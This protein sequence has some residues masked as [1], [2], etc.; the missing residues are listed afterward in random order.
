[1]ASSGIARECL[2]DMLRLSALFQRT[3][4]IL[5]AYVYRP[6]AVAEAD[7]EYLAGETLPYIDHVRDGL[8]WTLRASDADLDELRYLV[9]IAE[10]RPVESWD[11][12]R[13]QHLLRPEVWRFTAFQHAKVTFGS[14]PRMPDEQV[15][16][17]SPRTYVDIHAPRGP[18]E[19]SD[20][21]DEVERSIWHV[22]TRRSLGQGDQ[23]AFRRTYAFFEVGAWVGTTQ[24][25][26]IFGANSGGDVN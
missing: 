7:V 12:Y 5:L 22:A 14:V 23:N 26:R 18:A 24:L 21:V 1:M 3:R 16:Y 10:L 13:P 17:P 15:S 9:Q 8:R 19:L 4:E 11:S 2:F 6:E 20:R 25:R